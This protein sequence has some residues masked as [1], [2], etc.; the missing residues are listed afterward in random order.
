[1]TKNV[2]FYARYSTDRQNEV[3]IETQIELGKEFVSAKGWNLIEVFSDA[4]ISS[5]NYKT[6]PGIQTA[7]RRVGKGDIDLVLCVTVDRI[8]RDAEHGNGFLKRIRFNDTE[9]WTVHGGIP[10]TDIEMALR[11]TTLSQN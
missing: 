9:L 6:R 7:L 3:S 11:V 2:L 1:M 5:S 10:V 8:S 4:V